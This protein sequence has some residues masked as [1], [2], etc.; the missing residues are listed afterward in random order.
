[1]ENLKTIEELVSIKSNNTDSNIEIIN[2]LIKRFSPYSEQILKIKTNNSNIYNLL[3]GINTKISNTKAI[4]LSGHIDT[5]VAEEKAYN[6][7][8]Y[9]A[10][11]IGNKVF[12]LGIID[13]KCYFA[14]IIDNLQKLKETNLPIIIAITGDEETKFKGIQLLTQTLIQ[15]RVWPHLLNHWRTNKSLSLYC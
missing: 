14:T 2:Y 15:R 8:P 4:I 6:T 1:M 9:Y 7:N 5:V 3:I 12:G 11:Q 10:T 13:M